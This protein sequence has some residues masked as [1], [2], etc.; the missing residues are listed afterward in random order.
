MKV[1]RLFLDWENPRPSVDHVN[2]K[3]FSP[4]A[5]LANITDGGLVNE[6]EELDAERKGN[7]ITVR[8]L[9]EYGNDATFIF[10]K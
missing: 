3:A 5:C 4:K 2:L 1:T 10:V 6:G 7:V 8:C 9:G